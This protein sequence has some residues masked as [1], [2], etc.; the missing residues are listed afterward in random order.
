M[1]KAPHSYKGQI[2]ALLL[3]KPDAKGSFFRNLVSERL[4][5]TVV[6]LISKMQT[7]RVFT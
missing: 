2:G 3:V 6:L 5:V 4:L 1:N 7:M